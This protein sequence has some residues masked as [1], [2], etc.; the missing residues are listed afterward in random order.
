MDTREQG[1]KG[2]MDCGAYPPIAAAHTCTVPPFPVL[3]PTLGFIY[4]PR[5]L[6]GVPLS[7]LCSVPCLAWVAWLWIA[8]ILASFGCRDSAC[9]ALGVPGSSCRDCGEAEAWRKA[10]KLF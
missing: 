8:A 3:F 6:E 4:F 5:G 9:R 1:Y 10:P 2:G 7:P